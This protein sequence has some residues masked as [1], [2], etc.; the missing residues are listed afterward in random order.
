MRDTHD[1]QFIVCV[2]EAQAGAIVT[3]DNDLLSLG[4]PFGIRILTPR[5]LLSR[6]K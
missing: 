1:D 5:Q 6:I 3:R 4:K 2:L